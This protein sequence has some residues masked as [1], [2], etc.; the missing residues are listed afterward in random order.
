[1]VVAAGDEKR[2][3][4][5]AIMHF[6]EEDANLNLLAVSPSHQ[7]AGIGRQLVQWLEKSADIAGISTIYLELRASNL[8]AHSF[9]RSL[10]YWDVSL[11]PGYYS[12]R[13]AAMRMARDLRSLR[14]S[15]INPAD[16][17]VTLPLRSLGFVFK[18]MTD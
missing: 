14:W 12:G 4:G 17:T 5:F 10:G 18:K 8:E 13:E 9:Y 15:N 6:G 1:M 16:K 3:L 11:W 7:R 2:V